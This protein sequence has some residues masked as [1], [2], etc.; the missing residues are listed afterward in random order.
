VADEWDFGLAVAL[1]VSPDFPTAVAFE[2]PVS[3]EVASPWALAFAS[4]VSPDF[5]TELASPVSPDS[6][7]ALALP[8]GVKPRAKAGPESPDWVTELAF[9][10]P[11][12]AFACGFAVALPELPVLPDVAV[13]LAVESPDVA[14]PLEQAQDVAS[15]ELPP[16]PE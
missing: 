16:S 13:G 4:P 12:V 1:P 2:S 15:P 9:E 7:S 3:P 14:V 5:V 6:A 8:N 10:S 11:E